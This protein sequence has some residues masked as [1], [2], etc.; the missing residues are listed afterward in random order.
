MAEKGQGV[1]IPLRFLPI[2][3]FMPMVTQ[4]TPADSSSVLGQPV[5]LGWR[6]RV[7]VA[8]ERYFP[9]RTGITNVETISQHEQAVAERDWNGLLEPL[10]DLQ[11]KTILDFGCGCG[12]QTLWL[13]GRAGQVA[14]CDITLAYIE[15]AKKSAF[16]TGRDN[17]DFRLTT[18][19]DLPWADQ[20][21]DAVVSIDTFE[22][23]SHVAEVLREIRRVL[24]PGGSFLTRFGPLFHGPLG[25]HL[26]SVTQV[27]W[28][29]VIL[30]FPPF[31]QLI[32][33]KQGSCSAQSWKQLGMNQITY[34][35]FHL[36]VQQ[37]GLEIVFM[38]R[39]PVRRLRWFSCLPVLGDYLTFGI[40]CHL[41]RSGV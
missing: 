36:A 38:N 40:S 19:I 33:H 31:K 35:E 1:S 16:V 8:L 18:G 10:G 23:V 7:L 30:G 24:K 37:A 28:A 5:A 14:G 21:F 41:R 4:V 32:T 39:I 29:H 27:P 13:A 34:R 26:M 12:G 9:V 2:I 22:H 25:Y 20:T 15:Q 17:I 6:A 11:N 3:P